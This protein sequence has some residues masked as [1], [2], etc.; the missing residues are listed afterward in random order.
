MGTLVRVISKR[1]VRGG[2]CLQRLDRL[3]GHCEPIVH[4]M[5]RVFLVVAVLELQGRTPLNRKYL[6]AAI[7]DD[8][9]DRAIL[10][11]S[12]AQATTASVSLNGLAHRFSL[13]D[14]PKHVGRV[15]KVESF[16]LSRELLA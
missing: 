9:C 6:N 12:S 11:L 15:N 8:G 14:L 2:G 16:V 10:A 3:T 13:H 7:A 1:V 5:P 4:S